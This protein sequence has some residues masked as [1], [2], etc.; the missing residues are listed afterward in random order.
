VLE[1]AVAE[2]VTWQALG[3]PLSVA[4]NLG[5]RSLMDRQLPD[6]VAAVLA[7]HGLPP[8]CLVLEIT[9][10]TAAS[11]LEV[12]EEVLGRLRRLGV[13]ISVDDFGTGYS[14]LSFLQRTAVHELKVDRSFVAGMLV[15][16][17]DLALVRAT[18]HLAHSLGARAVAEGV[19]SQA[20]AIALTAL[21]CDVA[22]GFHLGRPMPA[23]QLTA[24]LGGQR[25][26]LPMPRTQ[27]DRRLS[28]LPA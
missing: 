16:D 11:A 3:R 19:E 8:Q 26:V 24:L 18:V 13:E 25:A 7:R 6:D 28:S 9:E 17:S 2:C 22:Q 23:A 15:N 12:V 14:S 4:V 1:L 27:G 21:G 10:T 20:L 5:A